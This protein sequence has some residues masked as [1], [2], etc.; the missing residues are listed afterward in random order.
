[1]PI[2]GLPYELKSV[3][4]M[5]QAYPML[6][7]QC[8][9]PDREYAKWYRA[10]LRT[11]EP[12]GV[13]YAHAYWDGVKNPPTNSLRVFGPEGNLEVLVPLPPPGASPAA[14]MGRG[15]GDQNG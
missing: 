10:M 14:S 12:E 6:A 4:N 9:G 13:I 5:M 1:M 3:E 8:R 2:R 15:R 11:T 7:E